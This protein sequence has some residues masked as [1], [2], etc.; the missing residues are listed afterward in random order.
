LADNARADPNRVLRAVD[1]VVTQREGRY[2]DRR[3]PMTSALIACG[4]T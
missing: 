2:G 4:V 1:H 3:R